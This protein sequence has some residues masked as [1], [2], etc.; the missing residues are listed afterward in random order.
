ML[1]GAV[2]KLSCLI[3]NMP[4]SSNVNYSEKNKYFTGLNSSYILGS[5]YLNFIWFSDLP[6]QYECYWHF[7]HNGRRFG[8]W[9]GCQVIVDPFD[10][11]GN[12]SVLESSLL[13]QQSIDKEHLADYA[14]TQYADNVK[15]INNLKCKILEFIVRQSIYIR[16]SRYFI[17]QK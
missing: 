9:L 5:F 10:L 8:H 17:I 4:M 12:K 16:F 6:G 1:S 11:K 7:H 15:G 3:G 13:Y 14:V 2:F